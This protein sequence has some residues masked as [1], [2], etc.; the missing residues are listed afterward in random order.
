[1]RFAYPSQKLQDWITQQW[2]IL[3]GRKIEPKDCRWLVGPFGNLD[4]I[5]KDFITA[6]AQRENL[7]INKSGGGLIPSM[8]KLNLPEAASSR[9]SPEVVCF[10][11]HTSAYHLDF[12]VKWNPFFP[13][14]AYW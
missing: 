8:H 9:L 1:M 6:F 11:E 4:A 13:C 3:R 12:S 5:D 2:V 10:Y 14:L 7:V